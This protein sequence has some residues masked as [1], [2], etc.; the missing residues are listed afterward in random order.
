MAK[1]R[2]KT[3]SYRR[4]VWFTIDEKDRNLEKLI[5]SAHNK[6]RTIS[7]RKFKRSDG[8]YVKGIWQKSEKRGG[9]YIHVAAETPGDL[10]STLLRAAE[11]SSSDEVGTASPPRGTEYM[12]GDII[13][14]VKNNDLC[15]CATGLHE[16]AIMAY[17]DELFRKAELGEEAIKYELR[18]VA[19][20][21]KMKLIESQGVKEIEL[22]TTLNEASIKYMKRTTVAEGALK[23]LGKHLRAVFRGDKPDSSDNIRFGIV[24][25]TDGRMEG[26]V[27]GEK[28]LR[29]AAKE[30]IGS[31]GKEAYTIVT[32]SNQRI[33]PDEIFIRKQVGIDRH[34]KSVNRDKACKA[35]REFYVELVKTGITAQ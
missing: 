24:L 35:L 30:L 10:A 20:I 31:K 25:K 15:L 11:K 12:D 13:F 19:N 28:R 8:Q 29:A 33:G 34:G 26:E 23:V 5:Q 2:D 6:L 7:D 16:A 22:G 4:A 3:I 27:L 21:D 32:K 1:L 17:C 9:L 14:Y 18:K